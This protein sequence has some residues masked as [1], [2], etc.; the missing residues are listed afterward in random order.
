MSQV[1]DN[2]TFKGD[3]GAG[4]DEIKQLISM[5]ETECDVKFANDAAEKLKTGKSPW[6]P[7][8]LSHSNGL[9]GRRC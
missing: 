5:E 8:R 4:P 9:S 3:L 6:P 2:L 1:N 7:L